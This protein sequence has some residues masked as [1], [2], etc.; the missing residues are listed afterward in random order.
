MYSFHTHAL[1]VDEAVKRNK[2][3]IVVMWMEWWHKGG[4]WLGYLYSYDPPWIHSAMIGWVTPRQKPQ[5]EHV[6][7]IVLVF[8]RHF[9]VRL[10]T[11]IIFF[12]RS[13]SSTPEV[14]WIYIY[15]YMNSNTEFMVEIFKKQILKP[16]MTFLN[17]NFTAEVH[18]LYKN[19][20]LVTFHSSCL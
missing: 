16:K 6:R 15:I 2:E 1:R 19:S 3:H 8:T 4:E 10:K 9:L 13:K 18:F 5:Q 17:D 7:L 14:S 20:L 12:A 11:G